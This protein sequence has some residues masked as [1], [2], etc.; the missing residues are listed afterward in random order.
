[1]FAMPILGR[2]P[3]SVAEINNTV[4]SHYSDYQFFTNN[5]TFDKLKQGMGS[6]PA[7]P[8]NNNCLAC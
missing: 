5:L 1:M 7:P 8:C 4:A 3:A 6:F 2:P